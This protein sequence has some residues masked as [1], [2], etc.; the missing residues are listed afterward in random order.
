MDYFVAKKM[1]DLVKEYPNCCSLSPEK[2]Y[3]VG[4]ITEAHKF[5][6]AAK[7]QKHE[8]GGCFVP[9]GRFKVWV[10]V[11][12]PEKFGISMGGDELD[13]LNFAII[14]TDPDGKDISIYDFLSEVQ[15]NYGIDSFEYRSSKALL[16]RLSIWVLKYLRH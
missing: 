14:T 2:V 4:Y 12:L 7:P 10:R 6:G 8:L 1:R 9:I 11:V 5:V 3:D 16:F 13:L 15:K